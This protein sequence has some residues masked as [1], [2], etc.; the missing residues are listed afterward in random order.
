MERGNEWQWQE[1]EFLN[2]VFF[3]SVSGTKITIQIKNGGARRLAVVVL[4][5]Q[6]DSVSHDHLPATYGSGNEYCQNDIH[7]ITRFFIQARTSILKQRFRELYPY[8][9]M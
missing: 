8:R 5:A 1:S 9:R 7:Q 4:G 6:P 2:L 3:V